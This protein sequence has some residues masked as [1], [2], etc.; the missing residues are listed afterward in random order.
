MLNQPTFTS[1]RPCL[2]YSDLYPVLYGFWLSFTDAGHPTRRPNFCRV[3]QFHLSLHCLGFLR[4]TLFTLIWT[5]VNVT[6]HIGLGLFPVV[7][8]YGN[9]RG[10][11]IYPPCSCFWAIP[12]YISVLVWKGTFQPEGR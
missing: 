12:S 4:V 1:H 2:L 5:V 9:I 7:L 6:A 8:Q 11:T 10:K 3:G